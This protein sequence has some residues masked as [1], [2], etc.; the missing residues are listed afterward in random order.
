MKS[1]ELKNLI[2][3]EIKKIVKEAIK[4]GLER[5]YVDAEDAFEELQGRL[6]VVIGQI[7]SKKPKTQDDVIM[8]AKVQNI[9]KQLT[10]LEKDFL[11]IEWPV[12][13]QSTKTTTNEDGQLKRFGESIHYHELINDIDDELNNASEEILSDIGRKSKM[14]NPIKSQFFKIFKE[15]D[16]LHSMFDK[17]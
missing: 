7:N 9:L 10:K 3:E 1:Q 11:N 14:F 4:P 5:A 16:N 12:E 15:M 6:E 13:E 8:Q 2:K 17:I